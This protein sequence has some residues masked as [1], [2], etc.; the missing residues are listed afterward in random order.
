MK[1]PEGVSFEV[2]GNA[3]VAKGPGGEITRVSNDTGPDLPMQRAGRVVDL[4][5]PDFQR[6]CGVAP[7][8]PAPGLC[9][10]AVERLP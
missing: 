7:G 2:R 1:I 8:E 3:M 9:P 5:W 10:V 4:S 6:V